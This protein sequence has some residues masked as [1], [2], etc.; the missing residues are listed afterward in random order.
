MHANAEAQ[1]TV[2]GCVIPY[3]RQ[4]GLDGNGALHRINHTGEL[5]QHAVTRRVGNPA[6]MFGD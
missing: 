5:S 6:T 4:M 2:L 3:R 1:A